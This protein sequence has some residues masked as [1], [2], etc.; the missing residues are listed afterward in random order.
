[1]DHQ[2]LLGRNSFAAQ[3]MTSR[4]LLQDEELRTT[5]SSGSAKAG[6]G[7]LPTS[8][9]LI[10]RSGKSRTTAEF[11]RRSL[12]TVALYTCSYRSVACVMVHFIYNCQISP[13]CTIRRLHVESHSRTPS[14]GEVTLPPDVGGAV[15]LH[16]FRGRPS[17]LA[18]DRNIWSQTWSLASLCTN[19]SVPVAWL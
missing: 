13:A 12:A 9:V 1:M 3:A 11:T 8:I 6:G 14:L 2:G 4:G 17:C 15:D 16:C 5:I 7:I 19:L 18:R 10:V